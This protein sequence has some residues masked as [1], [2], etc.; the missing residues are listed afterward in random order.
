M[1]RGSK[2]SCAGPSSARCAR[3]TTRIC[4]RCR[5]SIAARSPRCRWR[6][7]PR[8][9]SSWSPIWRGCAP[10]PISSSTACARRCSAGSAPSSRATGRWRCASCGARPWSR[11]LLTMIGAVAGYLLVAADSSW[12]DSFVAP[13]LAGGRDFSRLDRVPAQRRSTTARRTACSRLRHL[14]VHPQR[15]DRDLLLRARLRLRR[16]D[17]HAADP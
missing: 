17:G 16:A 6:G 13:E 2:R 3:S 15:R 9:T 4:W 14:P 8:S 12:Y 11:L 1:G 5:S 7:R 10:A